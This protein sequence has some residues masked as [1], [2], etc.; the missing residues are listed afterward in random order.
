MIERKLGKEQGYVIQGLVQQQANLRQSLAVVA[1]AI[2][3]Y[4]ET[5]RLAHDLP[6]GAL[7]FTQGPD[8]WLLRVTPA[9][10]EPEP[11]EKL[12]VGAGNA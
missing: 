6:E 5:L 11:E 1:G 7:T 3:G 4:A 9:P 2:D 10:E 8:A 12:A